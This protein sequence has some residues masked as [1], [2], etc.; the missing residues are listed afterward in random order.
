MRSNLIVSEEVASEEAAGWL[1][2]S[3]LEFRGRLG[4]P[5]P[6]ENAKESTDGDLRSNVV[7]MVKSTRNRI[8]ITLM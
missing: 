4:R 1:A 7:V 2:K 6:R 8:A 5:P 3:R